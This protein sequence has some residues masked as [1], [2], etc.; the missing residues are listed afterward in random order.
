MLTSTVLSWYKWA[1]NSFNRSALRLRQFFLALQAVAYEYNTEFSHVLVQQMD[2]FSNDP[3][4]GAIIRARSGI[5]EIKSVMIENIE[6]V[7]ERGER[8]EL[9]V[10]KTE[11]LR[12][13]AF[14]FRKTAKRLRI[15]MRWKVKP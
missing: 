11:Y 1:W 9:L 6:R 3:N 15:K 13:V 14:T 2:Y 7:L 10:D 12:G 5:A 8:V 4:A